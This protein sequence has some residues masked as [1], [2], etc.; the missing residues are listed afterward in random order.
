MDCFGSVA[1]CYL[2]GIFDVDVLFVRQHLHRFL[3]ERIESLATLGEMMD[4]FLAHARI[5]EPGQMIGDP[6]NR[7]PCSWGAKNLPI[8]FAI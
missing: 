7:F 1:E 2:S 5:P 3:G 6:G 8:W 4:D